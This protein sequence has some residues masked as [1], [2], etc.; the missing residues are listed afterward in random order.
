MNKARHGIVWTARHAWKWL[1]R[2]MG[3]MNASN[4][5]LLA[6]G[7]AYFCALA[8]FPLLT[9]GLAIASV[10]ITPEQVEAVVS[11]VNTYLPPDIASL[12]TGQIKRRQGVLAAILL[13]RLSPSQ[14][15][16]SVHRPHSKT[17]FVRSM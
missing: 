9:V 17:P 15:R 2:F 16:S 7:I 13:S 4:T 8:F 5:M 3:D 14:S 11:Q 1:G 6:A 12:I 10:L